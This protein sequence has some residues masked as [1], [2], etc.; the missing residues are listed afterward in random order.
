MEDLPVPFLYG[1][2]FYW[3]VGFRADAGHFFTFSAIVL[4]C[5]YIAVTFTTCCI[6]AV[7]NFA[8]ASVIANLGYTL[9]TMA[10][11]YFIQSNTIPVYVR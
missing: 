3:M 9:Q 4:L 6:A 2:I 11:G 7:R 10:C 8:G 1:V 5:H